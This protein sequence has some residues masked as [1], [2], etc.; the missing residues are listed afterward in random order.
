MLELA[1]QEESKVQPQQGEAVNLMPAEE[2]DSSSLAVL[3]SPNTSCLSH[4]TSS[5][6]STL[7]EQSIAEPELFCCPNLLLWLQLPANYSASSPAITVKPLK[8]LHSTTQGQVITSH[9][10]YNYNYLGL[11][12]KDKGQLL[13]INQHSV[14]SQLQQAVCLQLAGNQCNVNRSGSD[15]SCFYGEVL[16]HMITVYP[17]LYK[18]SIPLDLTLIEEALM[19]SGLVAP[20]WTVMAPYALANATA[21]LSGPA[22]VVENITFGGPVIAAPPSGVEYNNIKSD[23]KMV[24]VKTTFAQTLAPPKIVIAS[25]TPVDEEEEKTATGIP[26]K[27]IWLPYVLFSLIIIGLMGASFYKY[28]KKHGSKYERRR[29]EMIKKHQA[30]AQA[31]T[32]QTVQN[33]VGHPPGVGGGHGGGHHR[34]GP[35][36]GGREGGGGGGGTGRKKGGEDGESKLH[37]PQPRKSTSRESG[38]PTP[39]GG[40]S[41]MLPPGTSR[42]QNQVKN[43]RSPNRTAP[44]RQPSRQSQNGKQSQNGS[45]TSS[46]PRNNPTRNGRSNNKR[47]P[48]TFT[49]NENGSMVDLRVEEKDKGGSTKMF[50]QPFTA[51]KSPPIKPS[52]F[53]SPWTVPKHREYNTLPTTNLPSPS[54]PTMGFSDDDDDRSY[55]MH[56]TK[57]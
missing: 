40:P 28:H 30:Q 29:E 44:K 24:P 20:C 15:T 54:S 1:S 13:A 33:Q 11:S 50:K 35:G 12:V 34:G 47:K 56:H 3:L 42:E 49:R 23:D 9:K 21:S 14:L 46:N 26:I 48:L 45:N 38:A 10:P 31:L 22:V 7:Q 18:D 55:L 41:S 39:N 25:T 57:L 43:R 37:R 4:S 27:I 2:G 36:G 51:Q 16:P 5:L 17:Q 53:N 32:L 6:V 19:K 52:N 8:Q